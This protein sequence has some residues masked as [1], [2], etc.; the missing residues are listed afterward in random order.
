VANRKHWWLTALLLLMLVGTTLPAAAGNTAQ[1][2]SR[3]FPETGKT[4]SGKFLAYWN[5][6]GGLAQLGLPLTDQVQEVSPTDGKTYTMQYFERM[7]L[8]LHPE[9]AGTPFEVQ[10]SLLGYFYYLRNY[11]QVN[12]APNQH[13]GTQNPYKFSETGKTIGGKFRAYWESH[14]GLAQQG[15]PVSDEFTEVSKLNGKSYT[16]QYFQRAVLEL[17]PENQAPN[18]VLLSQLG[19]FENQARTD[20]S[21]TDSTG[22]KVTLTKRPERI[23]CLVALCEDILFELG[24]E[25]V[26]VNDTFGQDPRFWGDKAKSFKSVGS[27]AAPNLETIAS[28]KPDLVIGFIPHIG[29]RDALKPIAPLFVMNPAKYQDSLNFL[30]KMGLLTGRVYRAQ[31]AVQGLLLEMQYYKSKSPNNKVPLLVFGRDQNFSIFTSASLFGSVLADVTNYPWP[32]PGA[33]DVSAPDQEPGSIQ[34]S[35]EKILQKDP[36][37]LLF[38]TQGSGTKLSQIL[39]AN[40]L[41]SQLKAVQNKQVYEVNPSMYLFGRGTH[42][43]SIALQ[44]AMHK[45]YPD[46]FP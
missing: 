2:D 33:G 46:V 6:H 45:I 36:D 41:W 10:G 34:Y 13:A 38:E 42:S 5:G 16:V 27:F 20:L 30:I 25:P 19:T 17:H 23:V 43:I 32:A 14:G 7:V 3:T 22:T 15:Y 26:G 31:Q 28:L 12:G 11:P 35:L 1:S 8:E 4:V 44:D 37:V 39:A 29:L 18:D 40:P 21:F 9:N 24:M